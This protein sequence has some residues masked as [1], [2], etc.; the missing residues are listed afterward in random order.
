MIAVMAERAANRLVQISADPEIRALKAGRDWT[1]FL[2]F[3]TGLFEMLMPI[4][5]QCLPSAAELIER[6]RAWQEVI[7]MGRRAR[8][9]KLGI[10]ENFWLSRW[11]RQVSRAIDDEIGEE[12]DN[13]ELC[14]AMLYT[15]A[16]STEAEVEELRADGARLREEEA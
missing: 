12:F 9:R 3:L 7:P 13:G 14:E 10:M 1:G 16:N 2:S 15:I 4:F 11:E 5:E 8:R 6:A